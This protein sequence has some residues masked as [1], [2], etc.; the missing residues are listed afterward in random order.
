MGYMHINN[1]YKDQRI[2]N[3]KEVYALEKIHGSSSH[4]TFT[5]I[6]ESDKQIAID[7]NISYFS[8]GEK[9]EQFKAIFNE[10]QLKKL[11]LEEI[12]TKSKNPRIEEIVI[13]GEVYGNKCQG[14]RSV[15][16]DK[17][18][19]IVFDVM[20]YHRWLSVSEAEQIALKLGLEFV[21]YNKLECTIDNLNTERDKDS[22]QAIRNGMG[23]G[24]KREGI[25]IRPLM[26]CFD[27]YGERLIAKHKR[28]DFRETKTKRELNGEELKILENAE[29][30]AEEWVT[31]QRLNHVRNKILSTGKSL[32]LNAEIVS[33]LVK[34]MQEDI[35]REAINEI[36]WNKQVEKQIGHKTIQLFKKYLNLGKEE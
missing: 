3:F 19:F 7:Y 31:E 8:G 2:F 21:S 30:I 29:A 22:V 33:L 14:M 36:I 25:V 5:G 20:I 18:K 6:F 16:G 9:L 13:Y 10:T 35:K 34:E 26:E 28:D 12:I 15:Y 24:K 32:Q 23:E 11:L 27:V 4:I 17:L 1:L